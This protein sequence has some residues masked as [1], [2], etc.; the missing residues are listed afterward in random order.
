MDW[1]AV[2]IVIA[3]FGGP[4]A[5]VQI[6]KYLERHQERRR[7]KD[8]T[9]RTLMSTRAFGNRTSPEHVQALNGIELTFSHGGGKDRAVLEAW[10][11]YRDL[12]NT[13]ESTDTSINQRLYERR[14]DALWDLLYRMGQA[15]DYP[16]DRTYLKNSCYTPVAHGNIWRDQEIIRTGFAALLSGRAALPVISFAPGEIPLPQAPPGL[17]PAAPPAQTPARTQPL[18]APPAHGQ[19][20]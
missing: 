17:V 3:T 2:A 11:A 10:N 4:V 12:L 18:Q 14:D 7:L 6:Q 20:D 16:F 13:P 15:V 19:G 5:A 8:A 9:F 1:S